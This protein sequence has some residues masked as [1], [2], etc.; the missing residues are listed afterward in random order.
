[1]SDDWA[2][3]AAEAFKAAQERRETRDAKALLDEKLKKTWAPKK[4]DE[5]RRV[6]HDKADRFNAEAGN[7]L[8]WESI[9]TKEAIIRL[10]DSDACLICTYDSEEFSVEIKCPP[11]THK[12]VATVVNGEVVFVNSQR[13]PIG[14]EGIAEEAL[15]S[16]LTFLAA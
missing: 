16:L 2:K 1:M 8:L 3:K 10:A 14:L 12:Y 4:W 9:R 11:I 5:L 7:R 6:F 15:D 13:V